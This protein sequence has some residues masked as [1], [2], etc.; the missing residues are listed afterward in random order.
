MDELIQFLRPPGNPD[1]GDGSDVKCEPDCEKLEREMGSKLEKYNANLESELDVLG[2]EVSA[3][4]DRVIGSDHTHAPVS[5]V[6][7]QVMRFEPKLK[8]FTGTKENLK[9]ISIKEWVAE[10]R[11]N[12]EQ[13]GWNE[14]QSAQY[15]LRYLAGPAR[16]RL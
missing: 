16:S 7:P 12:I 15:V 8:L 13:L 4:I 2:R 11:D 1:E 9:T 5:D 6:G 3:L 14:V 10:A